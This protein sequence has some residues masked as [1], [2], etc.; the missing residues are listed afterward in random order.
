MIGFAPL[1]ISLSRS[2]SVIGHRDL[3]PRRGSSAVVG[4]S[5]D[6]DHREGDLAAVAA[7]RGSRFAA[8]AVADLVGEQAVSRSLDQESV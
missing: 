4:E 1:F 2:L 3:S 7:V 5:F 8:F 6:L